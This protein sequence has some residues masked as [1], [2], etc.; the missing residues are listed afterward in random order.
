M[1]NMNKDPKNINNVNN[2]IFDDNI[3]N[4]FEFITI[5][6]YNENSQN[7][8]L[9]MSD[10]EITEPNNNNNNKNNNKDDQCKI[11]CKKL[12]NKFIDLDNPQ[13]NLENYNICRKIVNTF[14]PIVKNIV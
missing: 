6:A 11:D 14:Y 10:N 8:E 5:Q 3:N 9:I 4:K 1:N 7:Q 13:F 12:C 2:I